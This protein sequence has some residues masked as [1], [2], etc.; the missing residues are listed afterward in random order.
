MIDV[1]TYK[2]VCTEIT[3]DLRGLTQTE[4]LGLVRLIGDT[5]G[6]V[7]YPLYS[8]VKDSLRSSGVNEPYT[9]ARER[10]PGVT[11]VGSL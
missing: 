6:G 4:M 5:A 2:P 10:F 8:R 7:L 9:A 1:V 11:V 3:Y